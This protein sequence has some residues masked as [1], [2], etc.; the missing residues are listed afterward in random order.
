[1]VV[2]GHSV[3]VVGQ[4]CGCGCGC[5]TCRA[6]SSGALLG[7]GGA[8]VVLLPVSFGGAGGADVDLADLEERHHEGLLLQRTAMTH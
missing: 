5:L 1:M 6:G 2:V 8:V 4:Q 3:V 7:L